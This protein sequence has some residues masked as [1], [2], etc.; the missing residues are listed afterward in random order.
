[1]SEAAFHDVGTPADYHRTVAAIAGQEG[2][3]FDRG[4]QVVLDPSAALVR[5]VC[6]DEVR[7]GAGAH[8]TDC[9]L[10]DGVHVPPG[11][12]V[13]RSSLV[14]LEDRAPGPGET[15]IGDLLVAPFDVAVRGSKDAADRE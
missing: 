6:W 11:L 4:S 14:R 15:V 10:A 1:M 13:E 3:G 7:V 12:R 2:H 8:L 9:V 5:V